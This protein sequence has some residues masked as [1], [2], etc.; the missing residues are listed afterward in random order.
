MLIIKIIVQTFYM[1]PFLGKFLLWLWLS[2][3]A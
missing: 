2:L 3:L 1:N